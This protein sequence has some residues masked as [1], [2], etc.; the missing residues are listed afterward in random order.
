MVTVGAQLSGA[1]SNR[2]LV[3]AS[4]ALDELGL[5]GVAAAKLLCLAST[6]A[7]PI[8]GCGIFFNALI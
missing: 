8:G 1:S 3:G 2:L 6:P 4:D 7:L 5:A